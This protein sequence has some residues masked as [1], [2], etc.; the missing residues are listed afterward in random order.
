MGVGVLGSADPQLRPGGSCRTSPAF[1]LT[2][3]SQRGLDSVLLLLR[4]LVQSNQD[5]KN[6]ASGS[7]RLGWRTRSLAEGLLF[8]SFSPAVAVHDEG[9]AP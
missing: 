7:I 6:T 2:H 4:L 3:F 9:P 8:L 1:P 5:L